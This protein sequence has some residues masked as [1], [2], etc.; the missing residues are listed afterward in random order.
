M[1]RSAAD[2]LTVRMVV[3]RHLGLWAAIGLAVSTAV[4]FAL[5]VTTLPLSGPFCTANCVT[6]PFAEVAA[7]VPHDYI[8]MYP[9][10]LVIPLFVVLCACLHCALGA[11]RQVFSL[12]AL[13]FAVMAATVISADYFIQLETLQPAILRGETE[14]VA[15]ISQYNPH[16]VFIAL[17]DLGYLLA[18]VAF[19]LLGSAVAGQGKLGKALC[20]VLVL[21]GGLTIAAR[22][23][24]GLVYGFG[25]EYRFE[26]TAIGLVW[27]TLIAG[28]VLAALWFRRQPCEHNPRF[29]HGA[30]SPITNKGDPTMARMYGV[31][32]IELRPGVD[33]KQFEQFCR[34]KFLPVANSI[35]EDVHTMLLVGNRGERNGKYL[36][37]MEVPD[38]ETRDRYFPEEGP[39]EAEA[40][41]AK[42][43]ALWDEF[44]VHATMPGEDDVFTD[45]IVVAQ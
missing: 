9:A 2:P 11:E 43:A 12:S 18:A 24:M 19:L 37:L 14:G 27:S 45:Y 20:W 6:Y 15:L 39:G 5:A 36:I 30:C 4:A 34:E 33:P 31:H 22:I 21:G 23:G 16:G 7:Y 1:N 10:L 13:C 35:V 40:E 29:Q 25:L 28:G 26:V 44:M 17:E 38:L 42:H 41:V 32:E 3:P 8:W